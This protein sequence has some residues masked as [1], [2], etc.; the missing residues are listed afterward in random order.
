MSRASPKKNPSLAQT[1]AP[2]AHLGGLSAKVFLTHYWQQKPLLIRN[3]F[4]RTSTQGTSKDVHAN[5]GRRAF[6]PL[7]NTEILTLATY[8]DAEVRLVTQH[9]GRKPRWD[10][11]RGALTKKQIIELK[12][13]AAAARLKWSILVQD[14]QHFSYEAHTLLSHF[15]FIPQSRIDDLMVS[16]ASKGG[17]VGPHVDS[18]D[19]FLLQGSG[20]R[21][22]QVSH[23][24][25]LSFQPD[26]PLRIL[27]L[28]SP[29]MEWELDEGDMLYLPPGW[30]HDGVALTDDCVTWSVGFRAPAYQEL[31]DAYLDSMQ[32]G[33]VAEGRYTDA[34]RSPSTDT[35]FIDDALMRTMQRALS[36]AIKPALDTDTLARFVGCY[37]T[38]PKPHVEFAPPDRPLAA[39]AFAQ[40]LRRQGAHL[41]LRSRLLFDR[42]H[43]YLNGAMLDVPQADVLAWREFANGRQLSHNIAK[44][45]TAASAA[46]LHEQYQ[47]GYLEISDEGLPYA[48]G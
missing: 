19:V 22:W 5:I 20:R 12:R 38:Q 14:T 46:T 23:Q 17:G 13:D 28:F 24:A 39:A 16:Y 29:T 11:Q 33:L 2:L 45:L 34:K 32:E 6:S 48:K 9:A 26:L 44:A 8:D 47:L 27:T 3:A 35:A 1:S 40:A 10:L 25:D 7:S 15:D 4:A 42:V 43:F 31:L 36:E 41:D 21:R 37:L 30:A 18:Y